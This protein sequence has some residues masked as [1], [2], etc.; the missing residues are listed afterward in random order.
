[1]AA[2]ET[3]Q[4]KK[5]RLTHEAQRGREAEELLTKFGDKWVMAAGEKALL[6]LLKAE[7]ADELLRVQADYRAAT[8]L[9]GKLKS[10]VSKGKRAAEMLHKEVTN[11]G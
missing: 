8:D 7:M 11:N 6:D 3:A 4:E 10:A 5:L 9:Y 1:M 2:D